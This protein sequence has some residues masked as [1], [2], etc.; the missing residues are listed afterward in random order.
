M[1]AD[2]PLQLNEEGQSIT[3]VTLSSS[4]TIY[5]VGTALIDESEVEPTK[6]RLLLVA[7]KVVKGERTFEVVGQREIKGCAYALCTVAGPYLAAAVNSQVSFVPSFTLTSF[8]YGSSLESCSSQVIVYSISEDFELTPLATW[9]GSFI[10]LNL[11]SRHDTLLVGDAMRSITLLRFTPSPPSMIEIARDYNAHYM[12]A[13]E[14]LAGH[15]TDSTIV[16][17]E[18]FIGAE[19]DLNLFTVQK[20]DVTT[21]RSMTDEMGLGERGGF[22]LGEIVAKFCRGESRCSISCRLIC[23][24]DRCDC[25]Y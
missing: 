20:E 11:T 15:E 7:E 24:A 10:S 22:H 23:R 17:G 19:I 8:A 12:A 25:G 5:V 21:S 1:L 13:V 9:G 16:A 14:S 3:V 2:I 4:S 18:E 6:G